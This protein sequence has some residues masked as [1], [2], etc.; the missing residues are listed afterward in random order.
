VLLQQLDNLSSAT[1]EQLLK[2]RY[3]RIMS[4]GHFTAA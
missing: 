3:K 1:P 2:A 4:Y